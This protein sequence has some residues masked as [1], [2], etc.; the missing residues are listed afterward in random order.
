MSLVPLLAIV[1][2][3]SC[4]LG[5]FIGSILTAAAVADR[6]AERRRFIDSLEEA[7]RER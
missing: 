7:V 6:R 3:L 2:F 4:V 5:V 1:S